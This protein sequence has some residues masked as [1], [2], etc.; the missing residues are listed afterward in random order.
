MVLRPNQCV[1]N[2]RIFKYIRI[3]ID[4]YIHSPKYSWIFPKQIYSD[5]QLRLFYP[6]ECIRTFIRNVRFQQIHLNEAAQQNNSCYFE[7]NY[8]IWHFSDWCLN[9]YPCPHSLSHHH[10]PLIFI[11]QN[12]WLI[13]FI[14]IYSYIHLWIYYMDKYIRTFICEND[15]W[16]YLDINL[17]VIGSNKYI[18]I[19]ICQ[20]KM[21]FATHWTKQLM[22]KI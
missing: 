18:W 1:A 21:T 16:I 14:Y 8:A 17:W 11:C 19:F 22:I 13:F 20:I 15:N 12:I 9:N 6:H 5:N 10:Y 7:K 4:K 3:S 2:I